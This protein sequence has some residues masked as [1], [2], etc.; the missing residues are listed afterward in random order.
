[1]REEYRIMVIAWVAVAVW[2]RVLVPVYS[3]G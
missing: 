3:T 2:V 1:M